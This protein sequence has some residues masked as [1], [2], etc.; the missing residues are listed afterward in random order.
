MSGGLVLCSNCNNCTVRIVRDEGCRDEE[1]QVGVNCDRDDQ[2]VRQSSA[3][4]DLCLASS[5][6]VV[7][8]N[9]ATNLEPLITN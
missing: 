2:L 4:L 5:G 9:C 3:I 8:T 7:L 6:D 1:H